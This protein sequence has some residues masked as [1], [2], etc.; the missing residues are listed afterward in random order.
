MMVVLDNSKPDIS[1]S[2]SMGKMDLIQ[3]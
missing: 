1:F 2:F 3:C